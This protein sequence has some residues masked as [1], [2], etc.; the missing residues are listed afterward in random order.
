MSASASFISS[1]DSSRKC[2][3]RPVVAPVVA[4]LGVDEVLV[5]RR[6]LGGQDVVEQLDDVGLSVHAGL[7]SGG[8]GAFGAG[9]DVPGT[10]GG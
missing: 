8:G 1:I 6:E 10:V 5:D 7:L 4:H 9:M 3:A 2:S